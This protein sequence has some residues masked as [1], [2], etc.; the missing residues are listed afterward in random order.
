[1]KYALA[2]PNSVADPQTLVEF[3]SLAE[4]AGWDGVFLEDYLVRQ[5]DQ[6]TSTSGS[7]I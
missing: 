7:F 1:M 4:D 6:N 5:G 3:A 2:L